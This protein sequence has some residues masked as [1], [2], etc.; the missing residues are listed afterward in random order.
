MGAFILQLF[1]KS[2]FISKL[3]GRK[4]TAVYVSEVES[5]RATVV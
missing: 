4:N 5:P 1:C 2:K 3:R